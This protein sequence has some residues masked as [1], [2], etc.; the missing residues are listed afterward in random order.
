MRAKLRLWYLKNRERQRAL[1]AARWQTA[2]G[3]R[4]AYALI[5]KRYD[6]NPGFRL[7]CNL[8]SRMNGAIW[9]GYGSKSAGT[10]DLIG[11]TI[12]ELMAHLESK[13]VPGMNW[14]NRWQWVVDHV[15]PIVSFDLSDPAQ[16]RACFHFSNLQPL[17]IE[18]NLRK[19]SRWTP[20]PA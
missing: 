16:Q 17:W 20:H 4:K 9:R 13:F 7:A 12:P 19:G 6:S 10:L 18:D 8:R 15:R 5:K 3:K 14:E 1:A 2:E 11:C